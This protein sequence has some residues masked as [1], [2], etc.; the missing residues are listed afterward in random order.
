MAQQALVP[1]SP[2]PGESR[3]AQGRSDA[4]DDRSSRR[5]QRATEHGDRTP[6]KPHIG[7]AA[8]CLGAGSGGGTAEPA[9]APRAC[10]SARSATPLHA[11]LGHRAPRLR[12]P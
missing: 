3:Q 2:A 5:E 8:W 4:P 9:P 10:A 12:N 7:T 6:R 1:R 11:G